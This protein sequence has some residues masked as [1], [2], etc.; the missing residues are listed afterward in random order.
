MVNIKRA[1]NEG[2]GLRT[3]LKSYAA[4]SKGHAGENGQG[5]TH[6]LI[7]GNSKIAISKSAR[8]INKGVFRLGIQRD[9]VFASERPCSLKMDDDSTLIIEGSAFLSKSSSIMIGSGATLTFGDKVFMNVESRIICRKQIIIGKNSEIGW[10][11]EICDSDFHY[12]SDAGY[13]KCEPII[14]GDNVWIASYVKILK[15]VTI[16]SNSVVANSAVVTES[17]P[18]NCLVAG[19]PAKIIKTNIDWHV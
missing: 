5:L 12:L 2:I 16:G 10:N 13:E 8:I 6:F 3:L 7:N 15:G 17:I 4:Y 19:I 9:D 14:I 18:S 1:L 11:V